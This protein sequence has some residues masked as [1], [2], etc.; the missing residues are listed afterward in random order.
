M[1]LGM[2][3]IQFESFHVIGYCV[4]VIAHRMVIKCAGHK[5]LG[6]GGIYSDSALHVTNGSIQVA[7]LIAGIRHAPVL[8]FLRKASHRLLDIFRREIRSTCKPMYE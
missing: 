2:M 6:L 7:L 1:S 4:G 3:L 5:Q 8:D